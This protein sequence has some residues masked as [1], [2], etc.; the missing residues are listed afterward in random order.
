MTQGQQPSWSPDGRWI[1]F[2]GSDTGKKHGR[3]IRIIH[4][5]G[6]GERVVFRSRDRGTYSRGWGP[7]LEGMPMGPIVWSPDLHS[8]A[9]KRP[10]DRRT[11]VW[12]LDIVTGVLTQVTEVDQH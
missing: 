10:F 12:R 9:F 6:T 1:A 3:A 5:D 8:I 7:M 2:I 11:T 4:P